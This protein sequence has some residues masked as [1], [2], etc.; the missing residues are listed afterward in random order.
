MVGLMEP[1]DTSAL[2]DFTRGISIRANMRHEASTVQDYKARAVSSIVARVRR[3]G[4]ISESQ[5]AFIALMDE[6]VPALFAAKLAL[7]DDAPEPE[8]W[9]FEVV[10]PELVVAA[11]KAGLR[12]STM[13][14]KT[15][16]HSTRVGITESTE[17]MVYYARLRVITRIVD[18]LARGLTLSD[19]HVSF[20]RLLGR[21]DLDYKYS[22]AA[23]EYET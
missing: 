14:C 15:I 21:G 8:V 12:I 22:C 1:V 23:T 17:E 16:E 9:A 10:R 19:L 5:R 7:L 13:G 3:L 11:F 18:R 4:D 2:V 20:C 6:D